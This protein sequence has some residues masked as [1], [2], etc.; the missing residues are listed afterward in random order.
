[1]LANKHDNV[2]QYYN[3][4]GALVKSW[5][6]YLTLTLMICVVN[7]SLRFPDSS[8]TWNLRCVSAVCLCGYSLRLGSRISCL[9]ATVWSSRSGTWWRTP[10]WVSEWSEQGQTSRSVWST[11]V[12]LDTHER[13]GSRQLQLLELYITH[14]KLLKKG[15]LM[16]GGGCFEKFLQSC[17]PS[18]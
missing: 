2:N 10:W 12:C 4:I 13:D 15:R 17:R 8:S 1:M 7:K 9:A 16:G 14:L 5:F 11:S 18:V 3:L 6:L